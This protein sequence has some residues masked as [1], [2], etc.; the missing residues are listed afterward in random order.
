MWFLHVDWTG[1][2]G[3][4]CLLRSSGSSTSRRAFR[5]GCLSFHLLASLI[6]TT[7]GSLVFWLQRWEKTECVCCGSSTHTL[8]YFTFQK[9]RATFFSFSFGV[10]ILSCCFC[11]VFQFALRIT[12]MCFYTMPS[13]YQRTCLD[14]VSSSLAI[15]SLCNPFRFSLRRARW[16]L[17]NN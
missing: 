8:W 5:L 17:L 3:T 9:V 15:G 7:M 14:F 13:N 16:V 12:P 2:W 6:A 10:G 1:S 4:H 11:F